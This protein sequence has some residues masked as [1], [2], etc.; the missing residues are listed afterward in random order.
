[1]CCV[2]WRKV[3]DNVASQTWPYVGI[4]FKI[5][6]GQKLL[7]GLKSVNLP[8]CEH[9]VTSKQH[10]LKFSRSV[11][12]S[13]CI[14]ELVHS[15][16]WELL[17]ISMGGAKYMVTFIDDYSRRCWAYPIKKKSNVFQVF[18]EYKAR[19]E[20]ESVKRIKCLRIDNG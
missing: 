6:F 20:L 15:D 2:K 5:L 3:N 1:M 14:L 7:L 18:K 11:A 4:R 8:F 12:I 17:N 13:K 9:C 10:R 16:V 19:V